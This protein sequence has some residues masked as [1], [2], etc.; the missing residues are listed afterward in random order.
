MR[1]RMRMN[2]FHFLLLLGAL[3][4]HVNVVKAAPTIELIAD[5]DLFAKNSDVMITVKVTNNNN[6]DEKF[7]S[8]LIPMEEP[9]TFILQGDIF[10]I[11]PKVKY[12]GI[13]AK[14]LAPT[15]DDYI[16]LVPGQSIKRRVKLDDFYEF[17]ATGKYAIA[18]TTLDSVDSATPTPRHDSHDNILHITI[19]ARPKP[20]HDK[21]K[22]LKYKGCN[23]SQKKDIKQGLKNAKK[24]LKTKVKANDRYKMWFGTDSVKKN[25]RKMRKNYN[26]ISAQLK[27]KSQYWD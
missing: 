18:L 6:H 19:K 2:T 13:I 22:V 11:S 16:V 3:L 10:T 25:V 9:N 20:K 4:L 7:L 17:S 27:Q 5:L 15:V 23:K 1:M 24:V 12:V 8:W 14:R 26:K 21:K